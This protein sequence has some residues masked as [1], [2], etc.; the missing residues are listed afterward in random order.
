MHPSLINAIIK[1]RQDD[2]ERAARRNRRSSEAISNRR[3][4]RPLSGFHQMGLLLIRLGER[5]AGPEAPRVVP[6]R[7]LAHED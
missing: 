6:S 2:L 3:R 1:E 5:L 4:Q 7:D